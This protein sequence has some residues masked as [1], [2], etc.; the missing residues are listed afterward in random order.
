MLVLLDKTERYP[1]GVH[2]VNHVYALDGHGGA[3]D[4]N[5]RHSAKDVRANW[6]HREF[7]QQ[8]PGTAILDDEV[9]LRPYVETAP[10]GWNRPLSFYNEAQVARAW[11]AARLLLGD[12][13]PAADPELPGPVVRPEEDIPSAYRSAFG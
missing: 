11:S 2:A 7:P 12:V 3:W 13:L 10:A 4:A 8:K 1:D 6:M 9:E 5:G